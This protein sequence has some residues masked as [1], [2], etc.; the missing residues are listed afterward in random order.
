MRVDG[1]DGQTL[2]ARLRNK[3]AKEP[4]AKEKR[5]SPWLR[6]L[7]HRLDYLTGAELL[8]RAAVTEI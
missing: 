5:Y 2:Q 4:S 6:K 3:S 1:A 8:T 7:R